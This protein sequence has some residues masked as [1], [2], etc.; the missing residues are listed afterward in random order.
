MK[1]EKITLD[2][3]NRCTFEESEYDREAG[4]YKTV[5]HVGV[6]YKMGYTIMCEDCFNGICEAKKV[7]DS[8]KKIKSVEV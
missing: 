7:L 8:N 5:R 6:G 4:E 3:D 2:E 1:I